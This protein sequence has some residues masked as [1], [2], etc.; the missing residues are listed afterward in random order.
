ME[1]QISSDI[2]RGHIDT[3]LLR[4][5]HD[6]DM[7]GYQIYKAILERSSG[8][9]ELKEPTMYTSLRRLEAQGC[10]ASRWG[11]ETQ[12]GRRRYY[13]I[14]QAGKELYARNRAEWEFAR[15]II[16]TLI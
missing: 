14:S 16:D 4:L 2:I 12:G 11:E 5:L 9:Y 1:S 7:Y 10:I 6:E 8:E 13:S 3:I 15:R